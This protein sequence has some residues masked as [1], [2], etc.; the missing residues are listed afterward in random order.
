MK[1]TLRFTVMLYCLYSPAS[2]HH[3]HTAYVSEK[4]SPTRNRNACAQLKD[5][6]IV[7]SVFVDI[8][9][10]HPFTRYDIESTLDSIRKSCFWIEKQG[11]DYPINLT[12]EPVLHEG[13]NKWCF[14]ERRAFTHLNLNR[15]TSSKRRG[16][17]SNWADCVSAYAGRGLKPQQRT[18][19]DT[20]INI[21]NTQQLIA[22]LRDIYKTDQIVLLF[23]ING[24][25]EDLPSLA[26][27]TESNGPGV[28]FG[29]ITKKN[30]AA[31]SHVILNLFG[32]VDLFP[33]TTYP[34]FNYPEIASI[35]PNEIMRITHKPIETLSLSPISTYYLGWTPTL[36]KPDTRLL[37]HLKNVQTY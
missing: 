23:F 36:N 9:A 35:Y 37:Y 22:R 2:C 14:N 21:R 34:T 31:I 29:I 12:I 28:E 18:N 6:A 16:T 17:A 7:Y 25:I 8:D 27:N 4:L 1:P 15:L 11:K 5:K 33:N 13:K 24:Y 26:F 32:A 3:Y 30:P 20:K 19:L 10:L